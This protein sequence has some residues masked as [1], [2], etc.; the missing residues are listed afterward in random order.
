MIRLI[1]EEEELEVTCDLLIGLI[2]EVEDPASCSL[3]NDLLVR[4][5]K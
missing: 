1:L 3:A 4:A 5:M 2:G